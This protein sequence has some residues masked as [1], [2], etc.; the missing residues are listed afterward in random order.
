MSPILRND[1]AI[2]RLSAAM[3]PKSNV[4]DFMPWPVREVEEAT[5]D[6]FMAMLKTSANARKK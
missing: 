3:I 6:D 4:S 5:I 2:A 1:A